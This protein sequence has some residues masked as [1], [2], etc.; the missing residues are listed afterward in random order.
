[1]EARLTTLLCKKIIVAKFKEVKTVDDVTHE[2][3]KPTESSKEGHGSRSSVLPVTMIS[4]TFR[5]AATLKTGNNT[6]NNFSEKFIHNCLT[7]VSNLMMT[8]V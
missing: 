7:I 2:Q 5:K 4:L 1:L 6:E 3:T 8:L